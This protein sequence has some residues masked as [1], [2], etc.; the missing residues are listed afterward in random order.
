MNG[1]LAALGRLRHGPLRRADPAW[2]ALGRAHRWTVHRFGERWTSK[3]TIGGYGPFQ[4]NS[5][6]AFSDLRHWGSDH[7]AG[8]AACIERSRGA[9]CVFDV[10]A[11]VGF[12]TLPLSRA[13]VEGGIVVA[14][15]P[16][17]ANRRILQRH[18]EVNGCTNVRVVDALVGPDE[19]ERVTFNEMDSPTGMNSLVVK[20]GHEQYHQTH[21]RQITLDSYCA[22]HGLHP[23]VVK[24]DVEG[25]EVGVLRGARR[26]LTEDRP[27]LYLSVHPTHLR[28]LG[29]STDEL[30]ALLDELDYRVLEIG[31]AEASV[32]VGTEYEVVPRDR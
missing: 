25:A 27:V 13:V 19:Q 16:A 6:F 28:L 26:V 7:N 14:F 4:V 11:H 2:R 29:S 30:L 10:G 5:H 21:H 8:F 24:I 15:E 22:E 3:T 18:L 17:S 31:G 9:A 23:Q 1:I 12:V 20:K 32:V